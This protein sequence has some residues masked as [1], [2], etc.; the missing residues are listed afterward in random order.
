MTQSSTRNRKFVLAQRPKGEPGD[1][2]LR[3]VVEDLPVPGKG[4]MLLHN[5]FLSLDPY[6][7]G[8]MS[9]ARLMRHRLRSAR[10]WSA[11]EENIMPLMLAISKMT[12]LPAK[13]LQENGVPQMAN[14]GHQCSANKS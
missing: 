1:Q 9:D 7:H 10:S 6:M 11:R 8:R 3:L 12:Y 2:T 14:K 5:E 4:Q 13:F